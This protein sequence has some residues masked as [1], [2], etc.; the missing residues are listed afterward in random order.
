MGGRYQR[1]GLRAHMG[2]VQFR[3]DNPGDGTH[4]NR[5][6]QNVGHRRVDLSR[7]VVVILNHVADEQRCKLIV[8][9]ITI[10]I[11]VI[12]KIIIVVVIIIIIITITIITTM[13]TTIIK[14]K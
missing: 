1:H 7:C 13:I 8:I 2:R 14:I 10:T 6:G 12:I 5:K 3:A 11:I 9:I 4:A